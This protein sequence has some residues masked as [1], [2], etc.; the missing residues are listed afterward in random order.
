[1]LVEVAVDSWKTTWC[2]YEVAK[3]LWQNFTSEVK[4]EQF[5]FND[6]LYCQE[7]GVGITAIS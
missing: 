4:I 3:L 7:A 1:M 5:K 6:K 2:Q